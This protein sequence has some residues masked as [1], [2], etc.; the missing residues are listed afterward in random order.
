MKTILPQRA[1]GVSH[2]QVA[3]ACGLITTLIGATGLAGWLFDISTFKSILP[4]LA[5]M[6]ANTAAGLALAGAAL[7]LAAPEHPALWRRR[8]SFICAAVVTLVGLL[9]LAEY[10]LSVNLGIDQMLFTEPPGA[11][12]T[13]FPGRMGANTAFCFAAAG[14]AL[15]LL[16][17]QSRKL[18]H[19]AEVMTL[20]A[21]WLALAGLMGYAYG[22]AYLTR[23]ASATQMALHTASAFAV[24]CV[25]LIAA[26]RSR[27][28]AG[29]LL[30]ATPGGLLLRRFFPQ[31]SLALIT[32]AWLRLKGER[33]GW[34]DTP[35]GVGLL[36][37]AGILFFGVLTWRAA[38]ALN[39]LDAER[40]HAEEV[41]RYQLDLTRT[42][43]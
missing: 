28:F 14:G 6:K 21:F 9:T 11:I 23:I 18:G 34:Y 12:M 41:L 42:I 2:V 39:E 15:L 43:T 1:G 8:A 38:R 27:V 26:R 5:S 32:L 3:Q 24:L 10:L 29:M 36:V 20:A 33:A 37:T 22:V 13:P 17:T 4:H 31:A 40:S 35:F 30:S 16:N 25:G 19:L 7:I